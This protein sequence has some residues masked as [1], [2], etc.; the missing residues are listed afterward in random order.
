[1]RVLVAHNR[2]RSSSPSG[3]NQLVAAEIDLLRAGG[4]DVVPLL[5][6]SDDL[7]GPL[8]ALRGAPGPVY[9]PSG[10]R[11]FRRLL[12]ETRPDVVHLHNV[13]PLISPYVVRVAA[14][15]GIPVVQTVHNYRHGCVNGLHLRDGHPCTDCLGTRLGL[16][17]IRHAC[18]RDSRL[19]TVPM[20][21]G[22]VLHRPTWNDEVARYLAL[23]PFM[24]D[25]LVRTGVPRERITLRP[26]WAPDPGEPPAPGTDVLYVGRLDEPKGVDRLRV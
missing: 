4:V 26:S 25:L 5:T 20:T 1:M 10:V 9:S 2:Y 21:I 13:Y 22:Q 11:R 3:E 12:E 18:Y 6:D 16:P 24:A 15:A 19:Q 8:G 14:R 23:T 17:A 7:T